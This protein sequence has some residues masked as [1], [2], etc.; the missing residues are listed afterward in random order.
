ML[1]AYTLLHQP[2]APRNPRGR[3][4]NLVIKFTVAVKTGLLV[5]NYS[6]PGLLVTRQGRCVGSKVAP[7]Y[8]HLCNHTVTPTVAGYM[9]PPKNAWWAYTLGL[10]PCIYGLVVNSAEELCVLILLVTRMTLGRMSL[11]S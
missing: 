10:T 3:S 2:I 1:A 9:L 6:H 8:S 11:T 4:N 7:A 5:L